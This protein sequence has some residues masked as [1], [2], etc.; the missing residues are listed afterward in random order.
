MKNQ[1]SKRVPK[2]IFEDLVKSAY[3]NI[4]SD[5]YDLR[6]MKLNE[7]LKALDVLLL[8]MHKDLNHIKR[9]KQG[10]AIIDG[11]AVEFGAVIISQILKYKGIPYNWYYHHKKIGYN[12]FPFLI[13]DDEVI[14]PVAW[15]KKRILYGNEDS[16]YY[17]FQETVGW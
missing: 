11:V 16:L 10:E 6:G 5:G 13:D 2:K 7:L 4:M 17:K 1:L 8:N 3:E 9:S 14:F 15:C 12:T